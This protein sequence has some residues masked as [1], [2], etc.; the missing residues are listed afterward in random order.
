MAEKPAPSRCIAWLALATGG[1]ALLGGLS[2]G[3]AGSTGRAVTGDFFASP[4]SEKPRSIWNS[5]SN[6]KGING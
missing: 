1:V 3:N 5:S 4:L 6:G 2:I